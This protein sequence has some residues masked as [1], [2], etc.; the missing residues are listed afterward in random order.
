MNRFNK[1]W[2]AISNCGIRDEIS[3]PV[4]KRFKLSNQLITLSIVFT[5]FYVFVYSHWNISK[6]VIVE[7][8]AISIYLILLALAKAGFHNLSKFLFVFFINV[9]ML[10]LCLCFGEASQMHLLFIPVSAIPLVLFDFRSV[11]TIVSFVFFSISIYILLFLVNF[12]SPLSAPISDDLLYIMRISFNITAIFCEIIIIY[13]FISNYD[14]AEK[15]LDESNILLEQQFESIFNNSYD[16]LFVVDSGIKKIIKANKRAAELF[17]MENESD[18]YSYYGEDFHK[19]TMTKKELDVMVNDVITKGIYKSEII[20]KTK[21]GNEFWGALAVRAVIINGKRYQSVRIA[22]ITAQK[23]FEKKIQDSL[24]EKETLLSEIHHRVKNNLAVISG[25]L[26]LQSSYVEDERAKELFEESRSRIHSMA[27]IHDKLYQHET[28][29]KINFSEYIKD[30]VH[31][32]KSSYNSTNTNIQF[33][34][35]C[36]DIFLDIKSA[37][38]V[39]L[40]L[41]EL[42][43]NSFKHAFKGRATGE[44][45]IVCT[46]MGDKF[47]MMVS[48]DGLGFDIEDGLRNPKSLGLTL[49]KALSDQ[50]GASIKTNS[51]KGVTY[52]ISFEG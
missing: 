27:L 26:G 47:T 41:N 34:V 12:S 50:I 21:K 15:T 48:D 30:L 17:E 35:T 7:I 40:I 36:N 4:A 22:D 42:I 10:C 14:R 16:A 13:S 9:H 19:N 5:V 2:S 8:V 11:K 32:I 3:V 39:G 18:F 20:Y 38:P 46:K 29:A 45:K 52:Y 49:I 1:F 23:E 6:A 31:H 33:A 51:D 37:V 24:N 25:L 43:S 44:I 28:F